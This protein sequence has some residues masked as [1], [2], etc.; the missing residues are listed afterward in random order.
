MS[1]HAYVQRKNK[2][3]KRV[4]PVV[5][6]CSTPWET[7][8][9]VSGKVITYWIKRANILTKDWHLINTSDIKIN[10]HREKKHISKKY[11]KKTNAA[12]KSTGATVPYCVNTM[13]QVV[14]SHDH[15][16]VYFK[17][18]YDL[19]NEVIIERHNGK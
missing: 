7:L 12:F 2:D 9:K 3:A 11:G 19:L 18:L 6:R 14:V 1:Q 4:Q 10:W 8:V 15:I 16:A 13:N 5:P 17:Q